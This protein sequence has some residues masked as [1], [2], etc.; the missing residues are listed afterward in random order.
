MTNLARQFKSVVII[1][2]EGVIIGVCTIDSKEDGIVKQVKDAIRDCYPADWE[3]DLFR[4]D[5]FVIRAVGKYTG[6][7]YWSWEK[8]P[9]I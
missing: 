4:E 9:T 7:T 5:G 3:G 6:T 1:S 2:R 8:V